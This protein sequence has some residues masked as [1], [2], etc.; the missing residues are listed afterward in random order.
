MAP[1]VRSTA[2]EGTITQRDTFLISVAQKHDNV[3]KLVVNMINNTETFQYMMS[4]SDETRKEHPYLRKAKLI[5]KTSQ[6]RC[7]KTVKSV[8]ISK[9]NKSS[10]TG[11]TWPKRIGKR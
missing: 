11:V 3:T 2:Q 1:V 6:D 10:G 8:E 5:L 9:R 7:T 4:Q